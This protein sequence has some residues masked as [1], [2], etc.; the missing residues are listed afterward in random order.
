[1]IFLCHKDICSFLFFFLIFL[2]GDDILYTY[3]IYFSHI[4]YYYIFSYESMIYC[5]RCFFMRE[6]IDTYA[7]P[8]YIIIYMIF[9]YCQPFHDIIFLH[10]RWYAIFRYAFLSLLCRFSLYYY[11]YTLFSRHMIYD[12]PY[13]II[14]VPL[15]ILLFS[16]CRFHYY[17]YT[18]IFSLLY[19]FARHIITMLMILFSPYMMSAICRRHMIFFM[20]LWFSPLFTMMI[21]LRRDMLSDAFPLICAYDKDMI[22]SYAYAIMRDIIML[23]PWYASAIK[24][25][26]PLLYLRRDMLFHDIIFTLLYYA[27]DIIMTLLFFFLLLDKIWYDMLSRH[28]ML[29]FSLSFLIYAMPLFSYF[30][31]FDIRFLFDDAAL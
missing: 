14:F 31:A 30:H 1:M 28:A 10:E 5:F 23:R 12:M 11:Y 8:Y 22:F 3:Y 19:Y 16:L 18:M 26:M 2:R 6:A 13:D 15:F 21:L 17:W 24:D 29:L 20:I 25:M 27:I 9:Y 4:Y 7:M